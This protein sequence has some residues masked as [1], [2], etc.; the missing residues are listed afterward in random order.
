MNSTGFAAL[1]FTGVRLN[2]WLCV[3]GSRRARSLEIL[4]AFSFSFVPASGVSS[5]EY[6]WVE[7]AETLLL[8]LKPELRSQ[9]RPVATTH[10]DK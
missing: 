3:K 4:T 7:L 5:R 9:Q 2:P 8:P 6:G 1:E 10:L